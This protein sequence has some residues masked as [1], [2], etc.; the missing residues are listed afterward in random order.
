MGLQR[1]GVIHVLLALQD[2]VWGER[3]L[4]CPAVFAGMQAYVLGEKRLHITL[5]PSVCPSIDVK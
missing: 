5:S 1:G 3:A 4:P 2:M